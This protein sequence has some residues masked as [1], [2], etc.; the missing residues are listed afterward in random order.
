VRIRGAACDDHKGKCKRRPA[1]WWDHQGDSHDPR[2]DLQT[3]L[4]V[5]GGYSPQPRAEPG[6][7]RLNRGGAS[8]AVTVTLLG[9]VVF[10][11]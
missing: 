4:T 5:S 9:G 10:R 1:E 8:P 2:N 11:L 3:K 6:M 7:A